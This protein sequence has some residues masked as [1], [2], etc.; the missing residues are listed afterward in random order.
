MNLLNTGSSAVYGMITK[1]RKFKLRATLLFGVVILGMAGALTSHAQTLEEALANAYL[2]NPGLQAARAELRAK[3]ET[4]NQAISH[5]RPHVEFSTSVGLDRVERNSGVFDSRGLRK[6]RSGEIMFEQ[7]LYRGGQ[8]TAETEQREYEVRAQRAVLSEFEQQVLLGAAT[9]YI[10]VVRDQAV[11]ELQKNSE[12]VLLRQLEATRDRFTVG[13]VTR[14]DVSQAEARVA[15]AKADRIQAQGD[16]E[17]SR[18]NFERVVGMPPTELSAPDLMHQLP[19][20]LEGAISTASKENPSVVAAQFIEKAAQKYVRRVT[21]ELLPDL[22]LEGTLRKSRDEASAGST[23][24]DASIVATLTIPLYQHGAVMSRVREAKQEAAQRRLEHEDDRRAA[25]E[26]A[27]TAW[28]DLQTARARIEAFKIEIKSS[29]IA[30]EGVRQEANV[31]SRTVLD[32][33]DAEQELLDAQVNLVRAQ[34]DEFV[35]ATELAAAVGKLTAK[36]YNLKVDYY[37]ETDHYN[38]VRDKFYGLG[39]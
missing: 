37:D 36:E 39:K 38:K 12:M 14:T 13:E 5:W 24:E 35:A 18:T 6:P 4:I 17:N 8:T 11:I 21:G 19:E 26:V 33:L 1:P 25:I 27:R 31:G 32:V 2:T 16:L 28:E 29:D 3:D 9:A 34:S 15:R 20:T 10:N 7:N 30:L 23:R 22:S